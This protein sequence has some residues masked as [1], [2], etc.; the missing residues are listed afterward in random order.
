MP[1]AAVELCRSYLALPP[2]EAARAL[3]VPP[4]HAL[5]DLA[6]GSDGV[7]AYCA[8]IQNAV[9]ATPSPPPAPGAGE[10]SVKPG[11]GPKDKEPKDPKTSKEPKASKDPKPKDSVE[12]NGSRGSRQPSRPGLSHGQ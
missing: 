10:S 8:P 5:A 6:G 4:L 7:R 3:S 12:P 2:Q 9:T 1:A 11:K